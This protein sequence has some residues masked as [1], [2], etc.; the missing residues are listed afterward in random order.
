[1]KLIQA[2]NV[3]DWKRASEILLAVVDKLDAEGKSLWT[4]H[5]VSEEGLKQSYKLSEL[6]FFKENGYDIG[7]AFLQ[8]ADPDFWPEIEDNTSL[9]FHKLAIHPSYSGEGKGAAAVDL[10]KDFARY[11]QYRFLRVDCDDRTILRQFYLNLGFDLVCKIN[12]NNYDLVKFEL[13]I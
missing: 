8:T 10:I 2:S 13:P 7:V 5:Q 12:I 4:R 1:M 9:F 6:V 11:H 3:D